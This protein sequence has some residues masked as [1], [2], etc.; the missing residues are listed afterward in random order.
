MDTFISHSPRETE[1]LGEGWGRGAKAGW[2]IGL[3]GDLGSGKTQLVK[4]FARG[5]GIAM[6]VHSP[7][8]ALLNL[9]TGG[10]LTLFHI[11]LYRLDSPDQVNAAGLEQY[12]KP[13][14]VTIIEWV[15]RW[16]LEDSKLGAPSRR[17]ANLLPSGAAYRSVQIE[18][19]GQNERRISYEDFGG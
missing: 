9:Y 19:L 7:T 8:F 6:R 18:Q 3:S 5:L 12:L 4:G 1:L 14:G 10:R 16:Q 2:V 17:P 15:E 11:D 13:D